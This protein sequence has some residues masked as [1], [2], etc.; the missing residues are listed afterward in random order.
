MKTFHI[1]DLGSG[2]VLH[3]VEAD[4]FTVDENG[5]VVFH[6]NA[7]NRVGVTQ[8]SAGTIITSENKPGPVAV[9]PKKD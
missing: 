6:T 2:K 5:I 8:V 1:N 3:S 4:S 9:M 7:G